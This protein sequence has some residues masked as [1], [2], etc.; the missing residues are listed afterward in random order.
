MECP[1]CKGLMIK[2]AVQNEESDWLVFWGC[3]CKLNN[4]LPIDQAGNEKGIELFVHNGRCCDLE[5]S[6]K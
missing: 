5:N 2:M 3:D 1:D 4:D 6:F